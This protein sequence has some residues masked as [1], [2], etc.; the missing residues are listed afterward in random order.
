MI[1]II[2]YLNLQLILPRM[3]FCLALNLKWLVT[4]SLVLLGHFVWL[5]LE[6][7]VF[8]IEGA[9]CLEWFLAING[10]LAWMMKEM[11][12]L[13]Y[14]KMVLQKKVTKFERD[15][16]QLNVII[17]EKKV[18]E[19]SVMGREHDKLALDATIGQ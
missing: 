4:P 10:Y 17:V 13:H 11:Q 2:P 6:V 3:C 9:N 7:P 16:L 5:Q 12:V 15:V 19:E 8:L 18:F 14:E 1:L